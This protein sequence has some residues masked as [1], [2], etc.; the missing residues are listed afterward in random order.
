MERVE[1]LARVMEGKPCTGRP[2]LAGV[3]WKSKTR[4]SRFTGG[5]EVREKLG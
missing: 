4:W 2:M 3:S 5:D 1:I